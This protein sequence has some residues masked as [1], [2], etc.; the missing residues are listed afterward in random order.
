VLAALVGHTACLQR[1]FLGDIPVP[2][3]ALELAEVIE[4]EGYRCLVSAV[5]P[6]S[7]PVG[8]PGPCLIEPVGPFQD[9]SCD[10]GRV[11]PRKTYERRRTRRGIERPGPFEQIEL[12]AVALEEFEDRNPGERVCHQARVGC[13]LG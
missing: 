10:Q 13:S 2:G 7:V 1:V 12:C 3:P 5:D 9:E 8:Q 6:I 11:E 4:Q